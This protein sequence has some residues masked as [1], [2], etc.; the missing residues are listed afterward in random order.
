MD[1]GRFRETLNPILEL[2]AKFCA[3]ANSWRLAVKLLDKTSSPRS[4]GAHHAV[5][6]ST[7]RALEVKLTLELMDRLKN[8]GYTPS[9]ATYNAV[10][11]ACSAS[12][13]VAAARA[14]LEEMTAAGITY[15]GV[16]LC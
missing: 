13:E 1:E 9:R 3:N 8:E 12:G 2:A 6:A 4:Y 10:L 11:H 5:I 16:I 14:V 15:V 7:G